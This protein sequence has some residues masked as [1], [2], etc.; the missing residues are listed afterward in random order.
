MIVAIISLNDSVH[1]HCSVQWLRKVFCGACK[2]G[3]HGCVCACMCVYVVLCVCACVYL[4]VCVH[5][6]VC[7]VVCA[8]CMCVCVCVC[9]HIKEALRLDEGGLKKQALDEY[10]KGGSSTRHMYIVC[11][12]E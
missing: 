4:C 3:V 2:G 5:V 9:R 6:C 11:S 8:W 1:M 12:L 7:Y 10:G